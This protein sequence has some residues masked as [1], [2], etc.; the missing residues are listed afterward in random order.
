[1]KSFQFAL[2]SSLS[3][4]C[5]IFIDAEHSRC[6]IMPQCNEVTAIISDFGKRYILLRDRDTKL[7]RICGT[8]SY[9]VFVNDEDEYHF[10]FLKLKE[11]PIRVF[12]AWTFMLSSL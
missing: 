9:D 2:N 1:M 5:R 4:E 7:K 8:R 12:H 10:E 6:F 11:I 3:P